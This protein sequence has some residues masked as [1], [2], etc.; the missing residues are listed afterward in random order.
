[1]LEYKLTPLEYVLVIN[2]L[3][4]SWANHEIED[5]HKTFEILN[6]CVG[7]THNL[8]DEDLAA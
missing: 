5:Y 6:W 3:H 4:H 7:L 2:Q 1:M 8:S